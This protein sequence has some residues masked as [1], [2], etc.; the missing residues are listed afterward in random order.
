MNNQYTPQQKQDKRKHSI[1][2][3]F[4]Y[5]LQNIENKVAEEITKIV[6]TGG[7]TDPKSLGF[8]HAAIESLMNA[9]SKKP[10]KGN[11]YSG[12]PY[13]NIGKTATKYSGII[14]E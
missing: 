9:T 11:A 3:G 10:I 12:A 5:D 6:T 7:S 13:N 4:E 2:Q 8:N 1:T 14:S